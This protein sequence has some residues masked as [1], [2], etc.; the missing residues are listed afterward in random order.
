MSKLVEA[1]L[2]GAAAS[3]QIQALKDVIGKLKT[4]RAKLGVQSGSFFPLWGGVQNGGWNWACL[5]M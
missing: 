5:V 3:K 1:E 2:D 4:V